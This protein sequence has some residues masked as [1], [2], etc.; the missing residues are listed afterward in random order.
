MARHLAF[1]SAIVLAVVSIALT[2]FWSAWWLIAAIPTVALTLVGVG[3]LVQPRHS[4]WRNYPVI[5]HLR[6]LM[7]SLR[8]ELQQYFIERDTDGN[9]YNFDT[10]ALV[11]ERAKDAHQE[12]PFGT[13]LDLYLEGYEWFDHSL[14]P[15]P[16]VADHRVRVGSSQCAAPY[17]MSLLNVSAMSFGSL[18]SNAIRALNVGAARG[19][20]AHDTGEGGITDHHLDGGGDLI[21]EIGS[22]YFGCRD[23]AGAFDPDEFARTAAHPQVKCVSIKLS[24]GAKPGLGGVMPA[25]KVNAEIAR[26][27]GVAEG[28]KCVSPPAHSAFGTPRE[29]VRFMVRLRELA[30]G[31]PVGFKLCVGR[32]SE[33]LAICL[34]LRDEGAVP[35]FVI[36]DGSEGGTGAAPLE[37]TDHVGTPLTEGLNLVHNALV[38]MDLRDEV[39]VGCSGK[40]ATGFDIVSRLAQG[41]D[42]TNSARAMM[43]AL[44]CIQAQ[45]C[46]TNTCPVG[47]ATQDPRRVRGLDVEDKAE[48][49]RSYHAQTVAAA[50]G[51]IAA[52]G[53]DEPSQLAPHM[54]QRRVD[55][56]VVQNYAEIHEYL[57]PGVLLGSDVPERW[58]ADLAVA[59]PDRFGPS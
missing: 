38:G 7:E 2:V 24:Q 3:D 6:W 19:G 37:F 51:L 29:F 9:P 48:R 36:V 53:L 58:A 57:E 39:K 31:K 46:H 21:W 20:F 15:R 34:A 12:Q 17:D 18:S 14:A 54:L 30:G 13:E 33:F 42:Y 16:V 1:V 10:R 52:M 5:G 59:H 35:D 28:V 25:A 43:F 4:I 50:S 40:V 11:Y 49:V 44:G 32:R 55:P 26:V 41:A 22:G 56:N 47:V 23:A 27:R 8:P 45:R